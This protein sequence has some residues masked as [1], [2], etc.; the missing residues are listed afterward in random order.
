MRASRSNSHHLETPSKNLRKLK[1]G[2]FIHQVRKLRMVIHSY[3]S[4]VQSM[5]LPT[6]AR[7]SAR[8]SLFDRAP[9]RGDCTD[10][11]HLALASTALR[12]FSPRPFRGPPNDRASA[13]NEN[14]Q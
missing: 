14:R 12:E 3:R 6:G 13:K 4:D 7:S 1:G 8:I 5:T 2:R 10:I 11:V 9:A